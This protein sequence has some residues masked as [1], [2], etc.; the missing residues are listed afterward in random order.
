MLIR[1]TGLPYLEDFV[2]RQVRRRVDDVHIPVKS[3]ANGLGEN[4]HYQLFIQ[5]LGQHV[6]S[7]PV[8]LP[9]WL[10]R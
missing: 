1:K 8:Q 2:L 7:C 3:L 5:Q 4:L 9:S 10:S 6:P